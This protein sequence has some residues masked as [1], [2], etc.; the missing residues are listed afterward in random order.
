MKTVLFIYIFIGI[1]LIYNAVLVS[2]VQQFF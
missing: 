1:E 2:E